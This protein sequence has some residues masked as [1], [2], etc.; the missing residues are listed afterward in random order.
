MH[1]G[2]PLFI[3]LACTGVIPSKAMNRHVP[4]NHGEILDDVAQ[5]MA[6]GVQMVHLHARDADG[7]QT[8]DPEPYGHL[9]EAIRSLPDGNEL[10]VCVTT[11]GR[12]DASFAARS[13]V[14][15][16]DGR[17]RPDMASLTLSSMNFAQSASLNAPD[18]IRQLAQR[19]LER[20]IRP[21]LEVFDV[22]MAH[23]AGV[24]LKE[25]LLQA[26]LYVNVLLGNIAGAQPD[27]IQLGA[28]LSALPPGC[29]IAIAG[30]GRLQLGANGLGLLVADGVRTGLEDNLWF[31]SSRR[32][33]ASNI[34]LVQRVIAQA[35]LFE[36]PLLSRCE[37]RKRLEMAC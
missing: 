14:L 4:V 12:L 31:D 8:S 22:G 25:G 35:A 26:P 6:L 37:L 11:S 5:A 16:L 33:A 29:I 13:R 34:S 28:I 20:G 24:L 36:R 15:E 23:F 9:L 21:E 30:L 3:N 1:V 2:Q 10:I 18:T 27:L 7:L 32:V 19:M 17:A